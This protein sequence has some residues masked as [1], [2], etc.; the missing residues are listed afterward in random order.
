MRRLSY[1]SLNIIKANFG[2]NK[3]P[4]KLNLFITKDCNCRCKACSIWKK[5]ESNELNN[6]ELQRFFKKNSYFSWI[7]ITGG[8]IFLRKDIIEIFEII[9][10]SNK[11]LYLLHFPTNG[12]LTEK[13][14]ETVKKIFSIYN[15]KLIVTVSIDGPEKL[16]DYMRGKKGTWKKAVETFKKIDSI[17]KGIAYIGFTSSEYNSGKL[18]ETYTALKKELPFLTY[19]Q[20]HI[21]LAQNSEIYYMKRDID[22]MHN[23]KE[24]LKDIDLSITSKKIGFNPFSYFEK[25]YLVLLKKFLETG[26]Y[27]FAI[28]SALNSTITINP[29]G[30]IYPCLFFNKKLGSIRETNYNLD[31]VF[32]KKRRELK[33]N[34]LKHCPNCWSACE[35]Y[36][37]LISRIYDRFF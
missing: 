3:R 30:D 29:E 23:K 16:H 9:I 13:I 36:P 32:D 10:N 20:I 12:I 37:S 11:N 15:K 21:N 18:K 26:E 4:F 19:D 24:K 27:P 22:T 31:S 6:Q 17:K 7:D 28:C 33:K 35:A 2:L 34:I 25:K 1:F 5:K 8:E 14:I